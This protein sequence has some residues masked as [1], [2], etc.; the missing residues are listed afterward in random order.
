MVTGTMSAQQLTPEEAIALAHYLDQDPNLPASLVPLARKLKSFLTPS[1]NNFNLNTVSYSKSFHRP[2]ISYSASQV[3]T[4]FHRIPDG[5]FTGLPM[6]SSLIAQGSP[7]KQSTPCG[8]AFNTIGDFLS[9]DYA[10]SA[11]QIWT[12][13]SSPTTLFHGRT[14]QPLT[15]RF[16][17]ENSV[18]FFMNLELFLL[19]FYLCKASL[20]PKYPMYISQLESMDADIWKAPL[21]PKHE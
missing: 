14:R 20:S 21:F 5:S 19:I 15:D 18:C 12:P 11:D 10:N 7:D 1:A 2:Y 4:R 17:L 8:M 13:L 16:P 3:D 6:P 9:D